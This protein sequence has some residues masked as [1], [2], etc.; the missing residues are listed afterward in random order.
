MTDIP[1]DDVRDAALGTAWSDFARSARLR[2]E[3]S[4]DGPRIDGKYRGVKVAF[5]PDAK[6][7]KTVVTATCRPHVRVSFTVAPG[8]KKKRAR[9]ERLTGDPE[10]DGEFVIQCFATGL[11]ERV[12]TSG[13]RA[14]ML[15]LDGVRVEGSGREVKVSEPRY[16][17]DPD[18]LRGLLELAVEL[19]IS[20]SDAYFGRDAT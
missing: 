16:E 2:F 1:I 4:A 17:A 12:L 20:A 7:G 15:A 5:A 6:N 9:Y 19:A 10:F 8:K 13:I 11:A 3:E 14:W 18:R